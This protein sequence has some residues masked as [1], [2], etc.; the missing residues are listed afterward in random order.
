MKALSLCLFFFIAKTKT[1]QKTAWKKKLAQAYTDTDFAEGL[2]YEIDSLERPSRRKKTRH[3]GADTKKHIAELKDTFEKTQTEPKHKH[4]QICKKY[5]KVFELLSKG[6]LNKLKKKK[7]SWGNP[8]ERKLTKTLH[9]LEGKTSEKNQKILDRAE[10]AVRKEETEAAC[11]LIDEAGR[12]IDPKNEKDVARYENLSSSF[13][14][15][16]KRKKSKCVLVPDVQ[17]QTQCPKNGEKALGKLERKLK[18]EKKKT[19]RL[20]NSLRERGAERG[21][22]KNGLG[23]RRMLDKETKKLHKKLI[24]KL[25]RLYGKGDSHGVRDFIRNRIG[26]GEYVAGLERGNG[27]YAL[28]DSL[29]MGSRSKIPAVA[30]RAFITDEVFLRTALRILRLSATPKRKLKLITEE[31]LRTKWSEGPFCVGR[32]S[33]GQGE[34]YLQH[35]P[36]KRKKGMFIPGYGWYWKRKGR[37]YKR[38]SE[39]HDGEREQSSRLRK[40]LDRMKREIKKMK[41]ERKIKTPAEKTLGQYKELLRGR[42]LLDNVVSRR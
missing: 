42:S 26:Y 29:F 30:N 41:G 38:V 23:P 22:M 33:L 14:R 17:E 27:W 34:G 9:R 12:K 31:S 13:E 19:R 40:E 37:P 5:K 39:Y 21:C 4:R 35:P 1:M 36:G 15:L 24:D 10:R 25:L 7:W 32:L 11:R 18:K 16:A 2:L 3:T 28:L 20:E 6:K 8:T